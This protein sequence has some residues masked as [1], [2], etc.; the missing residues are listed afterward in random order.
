MES[1]KIYIDGILW[2]AFYSQSKF[3]TE[4]LRLE[5][6]FNVL[7]ATSLGDYEMGSLLESS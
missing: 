6:K 5:K 4:C 2:R 7:M 1:Y 3:K